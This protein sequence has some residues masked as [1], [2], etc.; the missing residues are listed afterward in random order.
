MTIGIPDPPLSS[1]DELPLGVKGID[2]PRIGLLET[3]KVLLKR[4]KFARSP[5]VAP[6]LIERKALR[7]GADEGSVFL[8]RINETSRPSVLP[9]SYS[10]CTPGVNSRFNH[11]TKFSECRR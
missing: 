10:F 8:I 7:K 9:N 3:S 11:L 6:W 4:P 1:A 5:C 2:R